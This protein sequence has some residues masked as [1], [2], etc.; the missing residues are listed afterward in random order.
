MLGTMVLLWAFLCL[1]G[2]AGVLVFMVLGVALIVLA[3][4]KG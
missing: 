1:Y 2:G 4:R 3:C